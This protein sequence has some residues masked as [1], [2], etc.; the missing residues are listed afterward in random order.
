[1]SI[2][3]GVGLQF[4]RLYV[5]AATSR[6]RRSR[7]T[8]SPPVYSD[9]DKR[10]EVKRETCYF[11]GTLANSGVAR[12]RRGVVL[13]NSRE[14][15]KLSGPV[16]LCCGTPNHGIRGLRCPTWLPR[17]TSAS[18]PGPTKRRTTRGATLAPGFPRIHLRSHFYVCPRI[19]A[20]SFSYFEPWYSALSLINWL[21]LDDICAQRGSK[22][23]CNS[24]SR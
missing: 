4:S 9:W 14:Y 11:P 7:C 22:G 10:G 21:P 18:R 1:M 19:W 5:R 16:H 20:N 23:G 6:G 8:R 13:T 15:L 2:P 17:T 12:L 24:I 3:F